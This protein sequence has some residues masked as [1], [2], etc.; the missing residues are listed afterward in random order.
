MKLLIT[1][2]IFFLSLTL[3]SQVSL[4]YP[5]DR[6][7]EVYSNRNLSFTISSI[8]GNWKQ[9]YL[10]FY[11][12]EGK[13]INEHLFDW[14]KNSSLTNQIAVG[15]FT[16]LAFRSKKKLTLV[17]FNSMGEEVKRDIYFD[18][19][20][21]KIQFHELNKERFLLIEERKNKNTQVL[22]L[23]LNLNLDVLWFKEISDNEKSYTLGL[24]TVNDKNEVFVYYHSRTDEHIIQKMD[25]E[26]NS[27]NQFWL[28]SSLF[29]TAR[30]NFIK[31][32][33]N[34]LLLVG[35]DYDTFSTEPTSLPI[36][37]FT[38]YLQ[39]ELITYKRISFNEIAIHLIQESKLDEQ[40][41]RFPVLE[42]FDAKLKGESFSLITEGYF[43]NW[44]NAPA[45]KALESNFDNQILYSDFETEDVYI[46]NFD[47]DSVSVK[48]IWK[49]RIL[50]S[51]PNLIMR[52]A[53]NLVRLAHE[54][55]LF[56][57]QQVEGNQIYVK[58]ISKNRSYFNVLHYLENEYD[59]PESRFYFGPVKAFQWNSSTFKK[60]FNSP[61]YLKEDIVFVYNTG[62]VIF[63][64]EK[65]KGGITLTYLENVEE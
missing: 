26:G 33:E 31:A 2:L 46:V 45:I 22:A 1:Q 43:M 24:S 32:F 57:I 39:N 52:N 44:R 49:P 18:V 53:K 5:N 28:D 4:Y 9:K 11:S 58:G 19:K 35:H 36:G 37:L 60:Q 51:I 63:Y 21:N 8:Q 13:L 50:Y 10:R 34:K 55:A 6:G 40:V 3:F 41:E 61:S 29:L 48:R 7:D 25:D 62:K 38:V 27:L 56:G 42:V 12:L 65:L 54:N 23:A 59:T 14:E 16:L 47:S 17:I 64:K 20:I 15:K 30:L